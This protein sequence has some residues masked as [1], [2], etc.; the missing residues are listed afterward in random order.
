[1][2]LSR[3]VSCR[4]PK[5]PLITRTTG[6]IPVLAATPNHSGVLAIGY[7]R[8]HLS[9]PGSAQNDKAILCSERGIDRS[10][11]YTLSC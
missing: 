3:Y 5:E 6:H 7:S 9:L 10:K 8:F 1:M 2:P 4:D 11:F